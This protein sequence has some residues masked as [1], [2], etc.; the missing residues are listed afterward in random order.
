MMYNKE[1]KRFHSKSIRR[2]GYEP[3]APFGSSET[4][5]PDYLVHETTDGRLVSESYEVEWPKR[6]EFGRYS[7]RSDKKIL[8][9]NIKQSKKRHRQ[10]RK[11]RSQKTTS[12]DE[13]SANRYDRK[14]KGHRRHTHD[15]YPIKKVTIDETK[16][17]DDGNNYL[18]VDL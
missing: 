14:V 18:F 11:R 1:K 7:E 17:I 4:L 15:Y 8:S 13:I 12:I 3:V 6:P 10:H 5:P 16:K 9:S 2:D